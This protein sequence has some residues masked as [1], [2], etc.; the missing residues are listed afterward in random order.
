MALKGGQ[1][2]A[3]ELTREQASQRMEP[4]VTERTL[5]KYLDLASLY[6]PSFDRFRNETE[7]GL[8]RFAKLTNWDIP[9]L[10]RIR[11][12]ARNFGMKNLRIKLSTD[13]HYFEKEE[14]PYESEG[15]CREIS[16]ARQKVA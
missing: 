8:N 14:V 1:T 10:Q 3:E 11:T 12:Y 4:K 16:I 6:L 2:W 13:P 9:T 7:G 15:S 5:R